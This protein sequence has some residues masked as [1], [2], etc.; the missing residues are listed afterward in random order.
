VVSD[1]SPVTARVFTEKATAVASAI[2]GPLAGTYLIAK[3]FRAFGKEKAARLTL[4]IGGGF[5][6]ALFTTLALLPVSIGEKIPNHVVP[7][8][9]GL[10]GYLV[11]KSLQQQDI[12]AC[13]RAGGRKGSW[14]MIVGTSIV[15]LVLS[16][17]YFFALVLATPSPQQIFEGTPYKF[18]ATGSTI[19]YDKATIS[20]ADIQFVGSLLERMGYFSKSNPRPARLRK[21]DAKYTIEILVEEQKWSAP[22]IEHDMAEALRVLKNW[23]PDREFQIRFVQIDPIGI[24]KS[25]IFQIPP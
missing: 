8:I 22:V 13:L 1:A 17:G 15:A 21:E 24:R 6:V 2:G 3:N 9:Y 14:Q 7:L 18:E 16:L 5:T 12:E 23:H 19:Y 4:M 10:A 20:E 11:V 25:K